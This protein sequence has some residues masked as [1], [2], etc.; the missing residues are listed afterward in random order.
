MRSSAST[1]TRT[2]IN[3]CILLV[4]FPIF[5]FLVI[6]S[7]GLTG[8]SHDA[9]YLFI[10]TFDSLLFEMDGFGQSLVKFT[11]AGYE[12]LRFYTNVAASEVL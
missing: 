8:S 3:Y 11:G 10:W 2:S 6:V 4:L 7:S 12:F 1:S 5:L 9:D